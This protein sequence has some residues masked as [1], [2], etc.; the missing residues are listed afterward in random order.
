M[1]IAIENK[2]IEQT[3]TN[4]GVNI[5][6][7]TETS[8]RVQWSINDDNENS[9]IDGEDLF[10]SAPTNIIIDAL[11]TKLSITKKQNLQD[12]NTNNEPVAQ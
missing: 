5:V 12:A 7:I 6:A 10:D 11:F 2:T 9:I 1:K 4:I 3:A 8:S